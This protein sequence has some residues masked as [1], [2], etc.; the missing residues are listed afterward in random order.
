MAKKKPYL[1]KL[2][3]YWGILIHFGQ[4]YTMVLLLH[5]DSHPLVDMSTET[6]TAH[7]R[8][9]LML[10]QGFLFIWIKQEFRPSLSLPLSLSLSLSLYILN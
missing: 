2:Q 9:S 4:K 10:S 3:Y 7:I 8:E 1:V 5:Q 6:T